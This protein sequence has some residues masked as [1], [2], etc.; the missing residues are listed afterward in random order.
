MILSGLL[1]P[2]IIETILG[3]ASVKQIFFQ[4][5]Q[6]IIAGCSVV[7][8]KIE[9][10]TKLRVFRNDQKIGEGEILNLKKFENQVKDVGEGNDCGIKFHGNGELQA[11]DILESYKMERKKRTVA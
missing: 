10:K 1:E 11:G 2:E 9:N 4:K 6:E 5:K 7:S 3:R 8:G